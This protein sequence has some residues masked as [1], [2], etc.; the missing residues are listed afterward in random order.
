MVLA[1]AATPILAE[2]VQVE[3]LSTEPAQAG[4]GKNMAAATALEV[5]QQEVVRLVTTVS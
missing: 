2:A 4:V 1:A 3:W 5:R